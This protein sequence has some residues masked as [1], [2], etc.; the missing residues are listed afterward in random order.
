MGSRMDKQPVKPSPVR[1][2]NRYRIAKAESVNDFIQK[3]WL[4]AIGKEIVQRVGGSYKVAFKKGFALAVTTG[5]P[6]DTGVEVI[7]LRVSTGYRTG[8]FLY[9]YHGVGGDN[10]QVDSMEYG[11][12]NG[13]SAERIATWA[14]ATV[15]GLAQA[16]LPFTEPMKKRRQKTRDRREEKGKSKW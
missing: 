6:F 13:M 14:V 10:N 7:G 9:L 16:E 3:E 4:P 5:R 8:S 2:A 15:A 1:V 12:F 11:Q